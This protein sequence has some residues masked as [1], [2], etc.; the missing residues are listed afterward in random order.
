MADPRRKAGGKI[1][2]KRPEGSK[3]TS[4][5]LNQQAEMIAHWDNCGT[6]KPTR[7]Q[8]AVWAQEEFSLPTLPSRPLVSKILK[9]RS[10]ILA[11]VSQYGEME[12][13]RRRV[14]SGVMQ[15]QLEEALL[16]WVRNHD[17]RHGGR[18]PLQDIMITE[19]VSE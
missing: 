15:T 7:V 17:D 13:K 16:E 18:V 11:R 6:H 8:L 2:F 10:V 19:K 12:R 9:D 3:R 14:T 1:G 5:T 4:L